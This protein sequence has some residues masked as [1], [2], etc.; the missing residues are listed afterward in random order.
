MARR[1]ASPDRRRR[2]TTDGDASG[3]A[4]RP[5]AAVGGHGRQP[6]LGRRDAERRPG[7]GDRAVR[8]ALPEGGGGD[9]E[10]DGRGDERGGGDGRARGGTDRAGAGRG[11][12]DRAADGRGG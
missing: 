4:D 12:R 9:G 7:R 11:G 2:R 5:A 6:A 1:G 8:R 10:R 3:P